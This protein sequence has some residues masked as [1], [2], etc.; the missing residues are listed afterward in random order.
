[1]NIITAILVLSVLIVVH[2]L[3]HFLVARRNGVGVEK[4]SVGFGPRVWGVKRGDT[5]Y[6]L[7]A[8]PFGGYVK[9]VGE[10]PSSEEPVDEE[11]SF[12]HKSVWA[13]MMIVFSGPAFN[14]TFAVFLFYLIYLIGVPALPAKVGEVQEGGPAAAADLRPGDVITSVDG[15]PVRTF[16]ELIA[17]VSKSAGEERTFTVSR[18]DELLSVL[19]TPDSK[20]G[21]SVFGEEKE[22]GRIGIVSVKEPITVRY[23]PI[24]ALSKSVE[25]SL[26]IVR[27]TLVGIVKI[28]QRVVPSNTLGGPIMIV[29][30]AGQQAEMGLLNLVFFTA[31]LSIAL[32]LFNLFPIPVLDGGHL[33]FFIVEAL[34][35]RPVSLRKREIFQQVG[36]VVLLGIMAFA[37]YND[38]L[39][40][41]TK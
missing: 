1:L 13:R 21:K 19:I 36:L 22:V 6:L 31:F 5:E 17:I 4:F 34:Q 35:G 8:I 7:S 12:S 15:K 27:M 11:K 24:R 37:T 3:G 16:D 38:I 32:G 23:G 28:F 40:F 10:D 25:Q 2:E 33:M 14:L 20:M 41:F 26:W 18:E 9:M 39:R 30:M 29:Q